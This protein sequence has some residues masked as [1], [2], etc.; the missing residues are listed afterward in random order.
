MPPEVEIYTRDLCGFCTRAKQLLNEKGWAYTEINISS[1][2]HRR[3][4][5]EQRA[6]G[7][8]TFPQIFINGEHIGGCDQLYQLEEKG[9]LDQMSESTNSANPDDS[10]RNVIIIGSGCAGLTA[11]LYN[12]RADLEPLLFEGEQPGGQLTITTDV[13]NYPGFPEGIQ[14]PELMDRMKQQAERF[15][16]EIRSENVTDVDFS[17]HPFRVYVNEQEY[18]G[19]TII[20]ATGASAKWLGL[21]SEEYYTGK[22]V[23]SCATCDGF[24]FKDQEVLVIGGGDTAMEEALFLT[25]FASRVRILHRREELR[26]SEIMAD[27]ARANDKIEFLWNT[28]LI[29][30]LGDGD[31]VTG[32]RIVQHTDGH[33][34]QKW[35]NDQPGVV[36]KELDCQGIFLGIGHEPN[37][38][39]FQSELQLDDEGYIITQDDVFTSVEGVFA[40]G[41]VFDTRYRQ[42]VTAAGTGCQAAMEAERYLE[43]KAA[44]Q[45]K[46]TATA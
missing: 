7:M 12:A 45:R 5:M 9:V 37:T 3:S 19:R 27:R 16:T 31:Q 30:V 14:G 4:E 2:P 35:Q 15:G 21:E 23:S 26:A 24:F 44:E 29:E 1:E 22:G 13:E 28:E 33:P 8:K 25:K 43:E 20:S 46:A 40:A 32:A 34:K 6:N 36:E 17:R 10:V 38:D 41:D 18:R 39:I 42:A 11:G